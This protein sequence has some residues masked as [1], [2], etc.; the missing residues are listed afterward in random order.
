[1][2]RLFIVASVVC[3]LF[4]G[5]KKE[6]ALDNPQ[7]ATLDI[8]SLSPISASLMGR[9]SPC[10]DGSGWES[11]FQYSTSAD[12]SDLK[13]VETYFFKDKTTFRHDLVAL[14]PSTHYYYRLFL[15]RGDVYT[16][17]NTKEFTTLSLSELIETHIAKEEG[18]GNIR[19]EAILSLRNAYF[20]DYEYG[21]CVGSSEERQ[22]QIINTDLYSYSGVY[23]YHV[24][25]NVQPGDFWY[26]AYTTIDGN[27]YYGELKH[28]QYSI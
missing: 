21:F 24:L 13:E 9:T 14:S 23:Y 27:T 19:I 11:G 25:H 17:G 1:M 2:K 12:F 26:K 22:D 20:Y 3:V 15:R 10:I 16:Y 4:A 5:C 7:V 6:N 8:A 18:Q 28:Y